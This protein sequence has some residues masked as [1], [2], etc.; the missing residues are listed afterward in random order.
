L[1]FGQMSEIWRVGGGAVLVLLGGNML[2]SSWRGKPSWLS[3]IG[4][5]P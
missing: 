1:L 4:P 2:H 3:R 5:L